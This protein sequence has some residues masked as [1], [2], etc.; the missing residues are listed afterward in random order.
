MSEAPE[1]D[2]RIATIADPSFK[3][4][5]FASPTGGAEAVITH[6]DS[7][8]KPVCI[9]IDPP[10]KGKRIVTTRYSDGTVEIAYRSVP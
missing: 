7:P 5:V 9:T 3:V 6:Q 2:I 1:Q 10:P 4:V 8:R